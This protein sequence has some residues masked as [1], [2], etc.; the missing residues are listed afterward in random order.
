MLNFSDDC[1]SVFP[2]VAPSELIDLVGAGP[3]AE[4][5]FVQ[6]VTTV[7]MAVQS[8][9]QDKHCVVHQTREDLRYRYWKYAELMDIRILVEA[10][11]NFLMITGIG[12]QHIHCSI[13]KEYQDG[14]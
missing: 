13:Y 1:G 10:V 9:G 4:F 14:N 2:E 11:H 8:V 5:C 3:A 6:L 7:E 12:S